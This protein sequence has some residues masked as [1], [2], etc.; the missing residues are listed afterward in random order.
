MT[1]IPA[2]TKEELTM[3]FPPPENPPMMTV[4]TKPGTIYIPGATLR[5]QFALMY[6]QVALQE[7]G[8]AQIGQALLDEA[9]FY[10]NRFLG[11]RASITQ[12]E[13]NAS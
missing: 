9:F 8:I 1:P 4:V 10:A 7:R 13:Q 12:K 11:S 6:V 5:D 3:S 2:T